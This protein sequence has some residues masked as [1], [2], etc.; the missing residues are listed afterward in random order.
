MIIDQNLSEV[1]VISTLDEA[2]PMTV[3]ADASK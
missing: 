3:S 2:K 1:E